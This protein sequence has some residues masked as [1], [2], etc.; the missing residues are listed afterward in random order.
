MY[1]RQ[2][3]ETISR[4]LS[5]KRR[6]I[7]VVLGPRQVGK[8]T[9]MQQVLNEVKVSNHYAAADLPAPPDINW[10]SRQWDIARLK[11]GEGASVI[12]AG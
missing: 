1:K 2:M 11:A 12:L 10:I 8:T 3:T 5:E 4:R 9:A 6:F 7:Q